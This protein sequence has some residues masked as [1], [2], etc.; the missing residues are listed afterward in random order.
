MG[1]AAEAFR[2]NTNL[3]HHESVRIFLFM[4]KAMSAIAYIFV[5]GY[6]AAGGILDAVVWLF[7]LVGAVFDLVPE[8]LTIRVM[9]DIPP[10]A[11]SAELTQ[12]GIA[13]LAYI[14]LAVTLFLSLPTSIFAGYSVFAVLWILSFMIQESVFFLLDE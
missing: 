4:L 11:Q 7:L 5:L 14:T 2:E 9:D 10:R 3:E 1:W 6:L 12:L 13:A 8:L